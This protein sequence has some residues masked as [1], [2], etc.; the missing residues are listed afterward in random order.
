MPVLA[1]TLDQSS[2]SS[3]RKYESSSISWPWKIIGTPG[4][5][6]TSAEPI[7]E[8]FLA[9]HESASPGWMDSGT[10]ALPLAISSWL[11]V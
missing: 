4:D 11:S 9:H 6:M 8:R 7:I 10:R 3:S 1:S 2:H 5:V